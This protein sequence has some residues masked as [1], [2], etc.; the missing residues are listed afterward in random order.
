MSIEKEFE[1]RGIQLADDNSL[2][3]GQRQQR[4]FKRVI[5]AVRAAEA[6]SNDQLRDA[7]ERCRE[8]QSQVIQLQDENQRLKQEL[9]KIRLERT[10]HG[11]EY[12]KLTVSDRD[13][14]LE[15]SA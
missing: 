14:L 12:G 4:M 13:R 9:M 10:L 3:K 11:D 2:P 1:K 7:N 8:A 15:A 5:T 6:E